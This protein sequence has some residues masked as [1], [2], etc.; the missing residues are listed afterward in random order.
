M[1]ERDIAILRTARAG[2]AVP[3]GAELSRAASLLDE[4][5]AGIGTLPKGT[6]LYV[7][8]TVGAIDLL[9]KGVCDDTLDWLVSRA[10][11][12]GDFSS[13]TLVSA[14]CA[15]GQSAV[16]AAV[17]ALR[18]GRCASALVV[19]LDILSEFVSSGFSSLGA[20]SP[21]RI[22][23]YSSDRDGMTLGEGA[24]ALLLSAEADE[25]PAGLIRGI[26]AA[27]DASHVTAPDLQGTYL[28]A[29]IE[30]ALRDARVGVREIAGIVGHGTGTVYN[31][32]SE[33][34]ALNR[35][36]GDAPPPLVSIKGETGHTLG[37]TGVLQ[38]IAGLEFV[39]KGEWPAQT[40]LTAPAPGAERM[41][42]NVP[43]RIGPGPFLTLN[44][45]F[46]GI[47]SAL[48]VEGRRT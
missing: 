3:S 37:A 46:G 35:V 2:S 10:S 40:G 44:A 47:D 1:A 28:A 48:V 38:V 27:C 5:M 24:G 43:R 13:V 19:G 15:S 23:P 30:A 16:A 36:F 12:R 34:A 6:R 33:I 4:V 25:R 21:T 7:A 32:Q 18:A 26:G 9:E 17:R 45:G 31:D 29:A 11:S 42:A 41:V 22:R 14:A 8:S 20:V 39:R